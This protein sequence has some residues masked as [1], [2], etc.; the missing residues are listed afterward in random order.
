MREIC[1]QGTTTESARGDFDP[2]VSCGGVR[3]SQ[4]RKSKKG[5]RQDCLCRCSHETCQSA[6]GAN[7]GPYNEV[8]WQKE[9]H[10]GFSKAGHRYRC[11]Y[12][13][14]ACLRSGFFSDFFGVRRP[15]H[16]SAAQ[17]RLNTASENIIPGRLLSLR[18]MLSL[19]LRCLMIAEGSPTTRRIP[20][21]SV[22]GTTTASRTSMVDK[23]KPLKRASLRS[24]RAAQKLK[25]GHR[26]PSPIRPTICGAC[27]PHRRLYH[28]RVSTLA[29]N[30]AATA[31][32]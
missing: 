4:R 3:E 17:A 15:T 20:L 23:P 18:V 27:S 7:G 12:Y 22:A 6:K 8:R 31:G 10:L 2:D 28:R 19:Q 21:R 29:V 30:P 11:S 14:A 16:T 24:R 25:L 1:G 9:P 5:H 26:F 32:S 13:R